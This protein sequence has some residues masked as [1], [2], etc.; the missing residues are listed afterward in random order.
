MMKNYILLT[1]LLLTSGQL[2]FSQNIEFVDPDAFDAMFEQSFTIDTNNDGLI[3][4]SEASVVTT[5]DISFKAIQTFPE[6][7]Y[8]ISL[9][10]LFMRNNAYEGVLDLSQNPELSVVIASPFNQIEQ[11]I[12]APESKYTE[13]YFEGNLLEGTLVFGNNST[14]LESANFSIGSLEQVVF[15]DMVEV[16]NMSFEGNEFDGNQ[17]STGGIRKITGEFS[18]S[19][20]N[21][22][23]YDFCGLESGGPNALLKLNYTFTDDMSSQNIIIDPSVEIELEN[24]GGEETD[25]L[26]GQDCNGDAIDLNTL[27]TLSIDNN[28][29]ASNISIYPNPSS[30]YININT[31]SGEAFKYEMFDILGKRV[32]STTNKKIDISYL[33]KGVYILSAQSV[34]RRDTFKIIKN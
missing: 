4:Q 19:G 7:I 14:V 16:V 31:I 17:F 13:L 10:N 26:E 30:D 21:F 20:T 1:I 12:L 3:S 29:L 25:N 18:L 22:T 15:G 32:V 2:C 34:N 11:L 33:N 6:I 5:L 23:S 8:F 28:I 27:G 24:V 9:E